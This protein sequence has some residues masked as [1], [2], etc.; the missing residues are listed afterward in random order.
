MKV[1]RWMS[2]SFIV[3][4]SFFLTA[5]S[6]Y[7]AK[8]KAN[9]WN[10]NVPRS[11]VV[12]EVEKGSTH[13]YFLRLATDR[14]HM[15]VTDDEQISASWI[16]H[17]RL[18]AGE[19]LVLLELDPERP[20]QKAFGEVARR[21]SIAVSIWPQWLTMEHSHD[22]YNPRVHAHTV[23]FMTFRSPES[24]VTDTVVLPMTLGV[25]KDVPIDQEYL[26]QKLKEISGAKS[27]MIDGKE[28]W[29]R[30]RGSKQGRQLVRDYLRAEFL[31]LGYE[32][33]EHQYATGANFVAS[34]GNNFQDFIIV[35][36]H[37]DSVGNAGADDDGTGMV[38]VMAVA[39]ALKNLPLKMGVRFLGFD[40]E[41]RGLLGSKA[42]ASHLATEGAIDQLQG[43]FNLEM[44]GFDG[45]RDSAIHV[46]DCNEN[47]SSD[48]TEMVEQTISE[49]GSPVKK[50]QACTNR[51]D[52][53]SFWRYDRPAI[54]ISQNFFGGD[55]NPCYH[56][57]C[58][59]ISRI[60]FEYMA[61]IATVMS[62]TVARL[63]SP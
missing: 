17:V 37:L 41:E 52:H 49:I 47:R 27:V 53:A 40:Q 43:V 19:K 34:R 22:P 16:H 2:I 29:I 54:V 28:H 60:D 31:D 12:A 15:I 46:I 63:V 1:Y 51:S 26:Q 24:S 48:L 5:S 30:E 3:A 32:V 44:T 59:T 33:S 39:K 61:E 45:D 50:V 13:G 25:I 6:S 38:T 8:Q 57:Q 56:A 42:Y 55:S 18:N 11:I 21:G 36:A 10:V 35:S 23:D 14:A 7:F 20:D 58:D 9:V 4:F 62:Q